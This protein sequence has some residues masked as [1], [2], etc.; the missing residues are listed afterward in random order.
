MSI[1]MKKSVKIKG[2]LPGNAF[3]SLRGANSRECHLLVIYCGTVH[4][5]VKNDFTFYYL[6]EILNHC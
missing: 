6:Y 2:K 5:A 1:L 4:Y 3:L